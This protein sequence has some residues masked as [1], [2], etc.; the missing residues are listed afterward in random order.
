MH[1]AS[2]MTSL[3]RQIQAVAREQ[4]ALRVTSVQVRLGALS[5]LSAEH[6][7]HHFEQASRGAVSEGARLEI[8]ES[9]DLSDPAAQDILLESVD[10]EI[11]CKP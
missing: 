4:G 7:R 5:H 9:N 8:R 6:F 2:L 11:P 1:E 10:L 3:M